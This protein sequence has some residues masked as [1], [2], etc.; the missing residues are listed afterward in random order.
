MADIKYYVFFDFEMLCSD[1]GMPY[2]EMEAIRL[3]AVKYELESESL[4]YF[5][6]FIK[7]SYTKPL[8]NF[9]RKLTGIKD[10]DLIEADSFPV[11][12]E[13][14]L[15]WVGGVKRTQF[16]SW[17]KS[18]ISRLELDADAHDVPVSTIKKIKQRYIDL[19]DIFAKRV[20][21]N[22][23][24]VENALALYGLSFSG[25]PHNPMYD[26]L[27][28]F[29]IYKCFANLKKESDLIML[30]QFIFCESVEFDNL[31][32][33]NDLVKSE[34]KKDIELL[35]TQLKEIYR[36]KD[37]YRILKGMGFLVGKYRNILTN[38]S[39]IFTSETITYVRLFVYLYENLV[40]MY[41]EHSIHSSKIII[42][43]EHTLSNL[44]RLSV[45]I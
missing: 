43:D 13:E 33:I 10:E 35:S 28:T 12:L 20:S 44:K 19:Q 42:I 22:N 21:N 3:G 5:D 25:K 23:F 27:N 24:S 26:A 9:C 16:F 30:K 6:R 41:H 2:N 40:E 29:R 31:T 18:D 11:V 36:L 37:Y 32:K 34:L 4:S 8:S 1:Q 15:F 17:S 38:R 14:F 45:T 7:P 39:G